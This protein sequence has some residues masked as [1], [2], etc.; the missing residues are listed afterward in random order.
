[1]RAQNTPAMRALSALFD[2]YARLSPPTPWWPADDDTGY[3]YCRKHAAQKAK[4]MRCDLDGGYARETDS[5]CHCA[6]C[7]RLLDYTLTDFGQESELDHFSREKFRKGP[8]D[9]QTAFHLARA[10][11]GRDDDFG[12][13][14]IAARAIRAMKS[15]PKMTG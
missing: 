5:C 8:L 15:V 2:R 3:D 6:V 13:I 11:Y 7:G 9:R 1:M 12:A 4:E 14:E 10:L